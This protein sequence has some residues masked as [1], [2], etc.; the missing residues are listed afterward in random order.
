MIYSKKCNGCNQVKSVEAFNKCTRYGYQFKCK[1]C[2]KAYR[3]KNKEKIS[4]GKSKHYYENKE[5]YISYQRTYKETFPDIVKERKREYYQKTKQE[6]NIKIKKRKEKDSLFKF[7]CNVR[8]LITGSFSRQGGFKK[9]SKTEQLLGCSITELRAHLAKQFLPGMSLENHGEWHI[10]HIIP[11]ASAKT[12]AEIEALCH[13]TNLQP[14]WAKDN[15]KK[16]ARNA[17]T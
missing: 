16:G 9:N 8:T 17:N 4:I 5:H 12:Q 1:E 11:L 2:R 7:S 3:N 13:Y 10:D 15:M 6:V 14:L